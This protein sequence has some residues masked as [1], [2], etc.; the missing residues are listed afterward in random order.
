MG[1]DWRPHP[2]TPENLIQPG[3]KGPQSA[4]PW[5]APVLREAL[6]RSAPHTSLWSA[7]VANAH[8]GNFILR[9]NGGP[10]GAGCVL[11]IFS[12]VPTA[13]EISTPRP[14]LEGTGCR[15]RAL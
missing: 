1:P 6:L 9:F 3:G 14:S 11:W 8:G 2:Q 7:T 10:F 4:D 13:D 5:I 12:P 15:W